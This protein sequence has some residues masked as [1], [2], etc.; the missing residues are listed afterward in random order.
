[1]K[2]KDKTEKFIQAI[3]NGKS[4]R[5]AYREVFPQARKWK[6]TTVDVKASELYRSKE[7]QDR[8]QAVVKVVLETAQAETI[9]DAEE[10]M[11]S[12]SAI[13]RS[14]VSDVLTIKN[15]KW[16]TSIGVKDGADLTNVQEIYTDARG[17]VRV[18]MY[19]RL[20][21]LKT[22]AELLNI[23]GAGGDKEIHVVFDSED[24]TG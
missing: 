23:G 22:L 5:K 13:A 20:D 7:V 6:D 24:Y 14:S 21:A 18:R 10:L 11:L 1:M 12:L 3:L 4:Q 16:G 19:S 2:R 9:V 15:T 8:L 17:N